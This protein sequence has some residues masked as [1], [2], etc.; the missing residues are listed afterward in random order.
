MAIG[1]RLRG[2]MAST[3]L[4]LGMGVGLGMGFG[5]G[6]GLPISPG[7][8]LELRGATYFTKP[9]WSVDL[10][11]HTSLNPFPLRTS[12]SWLLPVL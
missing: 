9:P 7:Q 4:V 3:G 6:L 8:A 2:A 12:P 5:M 11:Y 1:K 10:M